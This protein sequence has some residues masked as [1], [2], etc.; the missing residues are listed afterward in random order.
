MAGRRRALLLRAAAAAAVALVALAALAAAQKA[1]E[2]PDNG[3]RFG[4]NQNQAVLHFSSGSE[5]PP[6][7]SL[8]PLPGGDVGDGDSSDDAA[9]APQPSPGVSRAELERVLAMYRSKVCC[10]RVR[11]APSSWLTSARAARPAA[12]RSAQGQA[13]HRPVGAARRERARCRPV[14][15]RVGAGGR[16]RLEAAGH[17]E[18]GQ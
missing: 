7:G 14:S 15:P 17:A 16:A 12:A 10:E 11:R 3:K 2:I 18:A 4:E 6:R 1:P 9:L 5:E 8:P 13:G